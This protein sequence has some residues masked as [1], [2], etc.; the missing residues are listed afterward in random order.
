MLVF[1]PP[2][3]P[4]N[5]NNTALPANDEWFR[6]SEQVWERHISILKMLQLQENNSLTNTALRLQAINQVTD[7]DYVQG[8]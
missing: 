8:I 4:W 7:Y 1:Q 2:L 5:T 6:K 3:F